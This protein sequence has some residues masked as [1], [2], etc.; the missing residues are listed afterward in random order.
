MVTG[1]YLTDQIAVENYQAGDT[2]IIDGTVDIAV[3]Q[4]QPGDRAV[5]R[6]V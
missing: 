3:G 6:N 5:L 1:Q 2:P 4:Q